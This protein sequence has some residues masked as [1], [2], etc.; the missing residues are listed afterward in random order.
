M[1]SRTRGPSPRPKPAAYRPMDQ[2][3]AYA[4]VLRQHHGQTQLLVFT[5]RD[6]PEA[7]LQ[8]PGGTLEPDET[9]VQGVLREVAEESGLTALHVD[10]LVERCRVQD[11]GSGRWMVRH[12]FLLRVPS[13]QEQELPDH[14]EHTVT[15]GEEDQGLVFC[16]QWLPL[17]E[18]QRRL[19]PHLAEPLRHLPPVKEDSHEQ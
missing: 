18:A 14:W 17:P 16:Y 1:D 15:A 7:G 5:H 2:L 3:K 13:E 19:W 9:P 11:P 8:V 4:Y 6:H 12:F 10:G